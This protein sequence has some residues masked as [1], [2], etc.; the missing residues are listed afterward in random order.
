MKNLTNWLNVNKITMN[1][2]KIDLFLLTPKRKNLDFEFK[3]KL[4][5]KKL[6]QTNSVKYLDKKI[7][8]K[9]NWVNRVDD[10]AIKVNRAK[11]M[12]YKVRESASTNALKSIN[13]LYLIHI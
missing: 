9:L 3:I 1:N 5:R 10:A 2:A 8:K 7:V 4:N 6:L 11:A 12:L 13:R